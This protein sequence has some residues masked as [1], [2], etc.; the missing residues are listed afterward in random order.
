M[1]AMVQNAVDIPAPANMKQET[2]K[3]VSPNAIV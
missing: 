2:P 1:I 3:A